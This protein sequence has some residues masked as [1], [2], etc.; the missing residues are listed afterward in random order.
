MGHQTMEC[1]DCGRELPLTKFNLEGPDPESCFRCRIQGTQFGFGGYR[2]QFHEGTNAE[3]TRTAMA[4]ARAQGHDPVPVKTAGGSTPSKSQM[5][6][7]K[8]A[9]SAAS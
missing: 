8:T 1:I 2:K 6:K 5:E 7:L 3:R 9:L 4:E